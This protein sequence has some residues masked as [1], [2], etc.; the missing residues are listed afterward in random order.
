[1]LSTRMRMSTGAIF[2][3]YKIDQSCRFNDDDSAYL[4]RTPAGAADDGKTWSYSFWVKR[5]NLDI[6][7]Y[8]IN[9]AT[10]DSNRTMIYFDTDNKIKFYS[11]YSAAVKAS[12]SCDMLFRDVG[13]WYHVL[14]TLDALNSQI[15]FYVNN[16]E[17]PQT[18]AT[19]VH[20]SVHH[21]NNALVNAIARA[22]YNTTGYGDFYLSN[23][24]MVDGLELTPDSFGQSK[25]GMWIPK[26]YSGSYGTNGFKLDFADSGDLGNDVSGNNNDFT[27][28]GLAA[29]DQV[30]DSPTNNYCTLNVLDKGIGGVITNNG[31]LQT[32]VSDSDNIRSTVSIPKS[33]LWYFEFRRTAGSFGGGGIMAGSDDVKTDDTNME[34][35]IFVS[36]APIGKTYI[37]IEGIQKTSYWPGAIGNEWIGC[38]ID[39]NNNKIS[40]TNTTDGRGVEYDITI[41]NRD[42]FPFVG[43]ALNDA[44]QVHYGQQG[45][46]N[47]P[48]PSG[49]KA[50]NSA[51][52]TKPTVLDS[53]KG[54]DVVLYEGTGAEQSITDLNFQPDLVWIKNR[55]EADEHK[56]IDSV[57]GAT[58][59][60]SSNDT[61]IEFEDVNGLT[62]FLSNGFS[63][64][65]GANGYND[66]GESF[67]AWCFRM[68]TKYGLDIQTYEGTGVAHT[69]NHNLGDVPE[70][71]MIK[72]LGVARNWN[73]Y[74]HHALNKTDPETDYGI[75]NT[76]I[77]W[78]DEA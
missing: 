3:P 27:S 16:I 2:Y 22:A 9:A 7:Q 58:F 24:Q 50:L 51:N 19:G 37:T 29:N 78:Q 31:N 15:I 56:L 59:D 5:C 44:F 61:D 73:V 70:L 11:Y 60:L 40:F 35:S 26:R 67:V 14:I 64:G 32:V 42:Y 48:P 30:L 38:C 65:T 66:S 71:M 8:I 52:L 39:M 1:M 36:A 25:N 46:W 68:G 45:S 12:L 41:S 18:V 54:F 57:R 53:S 77:G 10:S 76:D 28:S 75:L 4:Y 63:L 21:I 17:M 33:G 55:D 49:F 69:I 62:A 34:T 23:M 74:H 20:N 13:S 47:T 72:N 43:G 6:G